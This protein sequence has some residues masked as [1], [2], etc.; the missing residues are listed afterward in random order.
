MGQEWR[1][2]SIGISKSPYFRSCAGSRE[3]DPDGRPLCD[4]VL[5]IFANRDLS[6]YS[7]GLQFPS[8][9]AL[10]RAPCPTTHKIVSLKPHFVA[11]D[12]TVC[13]SH[14]CALT[15]TVFVQHSMFKSMGRIS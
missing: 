4:E 14:L 8:G 10:G 9:A 1:E 5:P 6:S 13:S 2:G 11:Y 3:G 12:D 15:E 7:W